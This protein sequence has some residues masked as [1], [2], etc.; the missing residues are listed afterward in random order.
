MIDVHKF[1]WNENLFYTI[2]TEQMKLSTIYLQCCQLVRLQ[3][4]LAHFLSP[5]NNLKMVIISQLISLADN[6]LYLKSTL[7]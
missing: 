4:N 1:A 2:F 7:G 3:A 6:S 5:T